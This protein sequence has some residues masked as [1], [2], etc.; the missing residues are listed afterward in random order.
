MDEYTCE[1]CEYST[2]E[3]GLLVCTLDDRVKDD[4]MTC[5]KWI[6]KREEWE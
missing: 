5:E 6:R 2:D 1:H 4:D 3:E